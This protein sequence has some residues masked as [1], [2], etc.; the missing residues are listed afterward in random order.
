M[1]K[2]AD[3]TEMAG[4]KITDRGKISQ[5]FQKAVHGENVNDESRQR[6]EDTNGKY[7]DRTRSSVENGA[8]GGR[9]TERAYPRGNND[10]ALCAV[11]IRILVLDISLDILMLDHWY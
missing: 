1:N 7:R 11:T 8:A 5:K 6:C 3:T 2:Q 9:V 10:P 4:R